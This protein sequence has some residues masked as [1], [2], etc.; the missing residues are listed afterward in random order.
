[1]LKNGDQ[2]IDEFHGISSQ[3]ICS[4][5]S[6]RQV[7]TYSMQPVHSAELIVMS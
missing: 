3:A 7:A 6:A 2:L 4:A 1:M 5:P